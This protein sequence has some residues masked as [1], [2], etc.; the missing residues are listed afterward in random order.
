MATLLYVIH[1]LGAVIWVGGMAFALTALRPAAR[2]DPRV[3]ALSPREVEVLELIGAGL[4]NPEIADHLVVA[5]ST[6]KTHV[7]ALL[8][9]LDCRDRVALV[10]VALG[11]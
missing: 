7:R 11:G 4:S 6:V 1:V 9:K 10:R 5:E 2:V 3:Q 8:T